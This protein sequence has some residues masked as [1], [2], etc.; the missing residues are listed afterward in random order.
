[1]VPAS[2]ARGSWIAFVTTVRKE[3][4]RILRIWSQTILPP[5]ITTTLYFII[6]GPILG[7]RIGTM[8]G[9]TYLQYVTPGLIMMAVITNSYTNVVSSFFGAKFQH[10]VEEML[11]SPMPSWA[12][13]FGYAAGGVFRGLLVGAMVAVVSLGF[14]D[15]RV[16]HPWIT[17]SVATLTAIAFAFAGFIN[18]M[19]ARN[20][21]DVS[22]VPTF[23]LTPLTMLG[24]VFYSVALLPDLWRNVSYANPILYMVNAFRFGVLGAA[25]MGIVTSYGL[26]LVFIATFYLAAHVMLQ[27][28]VGLRS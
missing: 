15:L 14:A 11:V 21:D 18:A 17:L 4:S 1:M 13:L 27:R 8:E 3:V 24:G 7:N 28:G 26:L 22:I 12:I 20:F 5:V 10:H 16:A 19:I 23:V 2:R 6:F 9:F 25:D